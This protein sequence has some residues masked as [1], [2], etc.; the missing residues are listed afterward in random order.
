KETD[1]FSHEDYQILKFHG[2]YQQD[3]RD[4]RQELK[5][6]GKDKKYIFMIR[7][8]N[9]GGELSPEQW[10]VLNE[11]SDQCADGTLRITTRQDIQFH[12]VGKKNLKK[13]IQLLNS[14]QISTYG[15]CGDGN[16]NTVACPVS[17]I[18][19]E[20]SFDGQKWA[21]LITEQLS[22]KSKAYYEVWVDGERITTQDDEAETIYG[23]TYL[24]RKF[25]I[26]IGHPDDNCIDVHT[27][28]IGIVPVLSERLLGFNLMVGGGLGTTHRQAKTYPRLGDP[29]AFVEPARLLDA[30]TRIVEFQRDHGDR[31]DRKHA[32]LKYVVEEWGVQRVRKELEA[33]L[34]YELSGPKPVKLKNI[35]HH[36]GWHEQNTRGLWYVGIFVENGRVKDTKENRMKKGLREIV[37]N[38]RPGIRLTPLQDLVLTNIPEGKI[39]ELKTELKRYGIKTEK[40]YSPLRTSSMACPA[41][42][43]CGLALAEAERYLPS[44]IDELEKRGYG[45]KDIKMRMSGCPNSCSRPPVAEIGIIGTSPH[46]YNIYLGGNYEGTRLN[47]LFE[48]NADDSM[49]ADRISSLI[50]LYN[51]M[52]NKDERF[53]D[54]C[55]R[56]GIETIKSMINE[57][58]TIKISW[59]QR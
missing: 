7:T 12:G 24:P 2:I 18:R 15:A 49:L 23:K 41:L 48:E 47:K 9:P 8:K 56:T 4:L 37:R 5:K 57:I 13:A 6:E 31:A 30:V 42:P 27:H 52:K 53:G 1:H 54:F 20:S 16:R 25:K 22:Y 55:D 14:E 39:E 51:H 3:D 34:G 44:L 50:D 45:N 19:K 10:E 38:F 21:K 11:I 29:I 59:S 26:G 40:E 58:G 43:T 33:R 17:D 32:R 28:D 35:D 46:K 36:L